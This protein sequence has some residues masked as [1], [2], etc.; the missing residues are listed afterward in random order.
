ML[1]NN[2]IIFI[3]ESDIEINSKLDKIINLLNNTESNNKLNNIIDLLNNKSIIELELIESYKYQI[4]LL[5]KQ[6]SN[7]DN[8]IIN[9]KTQIAQKDQKI[10]RLER[11]KSDFKIHNEKES[12]IDNRLKYNQLIRKKI[13]FPF[14]QYLSYD[15]TLGKY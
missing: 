3:D 13:T 7:V 9:L 2:S 6:L 5:E 12:D 1:K 15:Y 11:I 14:N 4:K 10:E 8:E